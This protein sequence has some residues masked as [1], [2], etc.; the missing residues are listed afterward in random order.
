MKCAK[1]NFIYSIILTNLKFVTL[2]VDSP[3]PR[4]RA[5]PVQSSA[6]SHAPKVHIPPSAEPADT[7]YGRSVYL[8]PVP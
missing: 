3:R 8:L 1:C 6:I 7:R 5:D 4:H 2:S